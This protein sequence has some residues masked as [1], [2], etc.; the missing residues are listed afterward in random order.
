MQYKFLQQK[1][2]NKRKQDGKKT[3]KHPLKKKIIT[4]I[5]IILILLFLIV[6][7]FL[8]GAWSMF[9]EKITASQ[10]VRKLE[11]GLYYL[12]YSGDY[13]FDDFLKKGG[14]SSEAVMAEY[15]TSFL[16]GGFM[17]SNSNPV[18]QDFGCSTLTVNGLMGRNFDWEGISGSAMII[19]AIPQSG[20]ESYSTC[21]LDFLG[22]GQNW[23]PEGFANQYMSLASIYV[24][25]DG[26]NE[27]G[28]CVADL[29]N[30]DNEQT[31]QQTDK[32][33]L[34]TNSAIRLLLDRAATVEEAIELLQQ[35]D[36]NSAIG[37]S[38]HLAISDATGR[39]VVIEYINNELIVTDTP[40]VTNHYLSEGEKF[41][42]GNQESLSRYDRLME[43]YSDVTSEADMRDTMEAV[44]YSDITR[45]S[46]VYDL[47]AK[48]FDFYWNM[49]FK[50]P[51][52][53]ELAQ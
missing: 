28:L 1:Q 48:A 26:M 39:S 33:D 17:E 30:G 51:H 40:A 4:V 13:G 7:L 46:I 5:L 14:A 20:Y 43:M 31:H 47:E 11:D 24:P 50:Q 29:V 12:E 53:F 52:H 44:S 18:S 41:G 6:I 23:K 3:M 21:W 32:T 37:M 22:F 2:Q 42:V 19:H 8:A 49:Q 10:S 38:H 35:H 34:T 36:M 45:W 25:L 9:G 27:M 16:S 15:I